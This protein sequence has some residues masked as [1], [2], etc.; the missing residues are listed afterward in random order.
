MSLD[1]FLRRWKRDVNAGVA[2]GWITYCYHLLEWA[3]D[4]LRAD[5]RTKANRIYMV[6]ERIYLRHRKTL[7]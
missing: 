6:A 4:E 2:P 3:K 7:T 1:D 5:N